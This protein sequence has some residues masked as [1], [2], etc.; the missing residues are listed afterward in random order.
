MMR[1]S[2]PIVLAALTS[3]QLSAQALER[4]EFSE[5]HMGTT[6]RIVLYAADPVLAGDGA[7][8]AFTL[9][10][11]LDS[12]FSDYRTDSEV[13]L[14]TSQPNRGEPIPIS[15][16]LW[17]LLRVAQEWSRKTDGAFDVTIG[18][19]SKL[20]RWSVRRGELPDG[21]RVEAARGRVGYQFLCVDPNVV[22]V[23]FLREGMALDLGGIA[24]GF[25]ADAAVAELAGRGIFSVMVD[26]GGDIAVGEAP[27]GETGW[28][29]ALPQSQ[30][31]T[32]VLANAGVATSGD[33]YQR[34]EFD[35]V[36]YS[37]IIDP[38]TGLGVPEAPIVVAIAADATSADVLASSLTVMGRREGLAFIRAIPGVAAR[39]SGSGG[40]ETENFPQRHGAYR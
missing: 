18:P 35:G 38:A 5:P 24:K 14:L 19:L 28:R 40:Y 31:G 15:T 3:G 20:W 37:H 21:A 33:T 29:I 32:L 26:A 7:A 9:I 17:S 13:S 8:A 6:F 39:V 36:R 22:A 23:R 30:D 34:M 12:L 27:P 10:W 2:F 4:F 1:L 16:E 11:R 25:A